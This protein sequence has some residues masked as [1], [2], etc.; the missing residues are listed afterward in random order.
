MEMLLM[1]ACILTLWKIKTIKRYSVTPGDL[2][3]SNGFSVFPDA[4]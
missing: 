4:Y 3:V 2:D 1:S